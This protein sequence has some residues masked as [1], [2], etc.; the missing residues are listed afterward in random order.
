[1]PFNANNYKG[2]EK[3]IFLSGVNFD[4]R[5]LTREDVL[6]SD[7]YD[8]FNDEQTCLTLQKHYFPNTPDMQLAFYEDMIKDKS[9]I[10]LGIVPK[11]KDKLI[12]IVSLSFIDPINRNAEFS[13]VIGASKY[14]NKGTSV[15][16]LRLLFEHGFNTLNLH[17]IQGGSLE[18]LKSWVEMLKKTFGFTD[19]GFLAEHVYKDGKYIG[20]YRIGL[21]KTDF[22]EAIKKLDN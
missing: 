10:Q 3:N 15:E 14:R 11:G 8:W 18:M 9:K 22:I 7:W 5:T 6:N 4:L 20:A 13:I 12:G 1:M 19:E 2:R 17:K 16:T 21:L